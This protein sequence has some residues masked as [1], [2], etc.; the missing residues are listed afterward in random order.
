MEIGAQKGRN[1]ILNYSCI[2]IWSRDTKQQ[3]SVFLSTQYRREGFTYAWQSKNFDTVCLKPLLEGLVKPPS[4]SISYRLHLLAFPFNRYR[5]E[6]NKI[7]KA[8]QTW[9]EQLLAVVLSGLS[10]LWSLEP[11]L[12]ELILTMALKPLLES[13]HTLPASS[14]LATL[15]T[16]KAPK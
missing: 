12:L 10:L 7:K 9:M 13:I 14:F 2:T 11:A 6:G 8:R 15:W 16:I 4:L 5:L 3:S 1:N